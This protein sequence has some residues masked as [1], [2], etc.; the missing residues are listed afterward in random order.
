MVQ[1]VRAFAVLVEDWDLVLSTYIAAHTLLF[2]FSSRE[3]SDL[4]RLPRV[5]CA[6]GTD[7]YTGKPLTHI[8]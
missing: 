3:S 6:Q 8:K 4:F 7:T 2:S 5:L 1:W